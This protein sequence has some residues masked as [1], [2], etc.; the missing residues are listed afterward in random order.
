MFS[1]TFFYAAI[2]LIFTNTLTAA[3][4]VADFRG[5]KKEKNVRYLLAN[6]V[7]LAVSYVTSAF[8]LVMTI[9]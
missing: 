3:S 8:V 2:A 1:L 6:F 9:Q 5:Y 7:L 4:V